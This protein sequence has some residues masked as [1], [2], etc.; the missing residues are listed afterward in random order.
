MVEPVANVNIPGTAYI[1]NC[2]VSETFVA[3][4][5]AG[6]VTAKSGG[7][8]WLQGSSV[9]GNQAVLPLAAIANPTGVRD[10]TSIYSDRED[11]VLSLIG[12]GPGNWIQTGQPPADQENFISADD[13]WLLRVISVRSLPHLKH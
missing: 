2:T 7:V 4:T 10:T 9:E 3:A 6:A 1:V 8:V 13:K 11:K 12:P 5:S